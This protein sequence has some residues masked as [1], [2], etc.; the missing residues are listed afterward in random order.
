MDNIVSLIA[1][2]KNLVSTGKVTIKEIN[3]TEERM[4]TKFAQEYKD[5]LQAYGIASFEGHELTGIG[6]IKRLNVESVSKKYKGNDETNNMYVIE[7]L[8]YD[9]IIIW[10]NKEGKI[11]KSINKKTPIIIC[12]S[13]LEYLQ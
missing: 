3:E 12:S 6:N 1:K 10:Q 7:D 13:M 4:N 9:D 8:Y 2:K 5:Y 11:F